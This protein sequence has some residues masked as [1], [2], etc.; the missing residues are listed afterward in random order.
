LFNRCAW[1]QPVSC[2]KEKL[3][4]YNMATHNTT[5]K[6]GEALAADWLQ[7][8]AYTIL[9]KNW[10]F[11]HWEVDIIAEKKGTLHFIEVKTL[12]SEKFGYPEQRAGK[13]KIQHLINAAQQ[14]LAQY[15]QWQ[16]IQF[17]VLSITLTAAGVKYFL[18]EDVYL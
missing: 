3:H 1:Q 12:S 13:K 9:H 4:F 18:L 8:A 5:G 10:R 15:P 7:A 2:L 17:D 6:Q 11:S 14:Y 16:R